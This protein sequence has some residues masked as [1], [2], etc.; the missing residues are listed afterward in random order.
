MK[1][2]EGFSGVSRGLTTWFQKSILKG[3]DQ[4]NL[5]F[6]RESYRTLIMNKDRKIDHS[7]AT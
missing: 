3:N 5:E 6:I 2:P 7:N 4:D 1:I